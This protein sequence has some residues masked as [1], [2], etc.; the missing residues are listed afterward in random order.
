[1][2]T[3]Y[4]T[5]AVGRVGVL[6]FAPGQPNDVQVF[7]GGQLVV[8]AARGDASF[9]VPN[10]IRPQPGTVDVVIHG[11]PGRFGTTQECTIEVPA[12]VVAQLLDNAGIPRRTPLRCITCHG[13][14]NPLIGPAAAQLLATAR[15][16]PVSAPDGFCVVA[17]NQ[18]RIDLGDWNPDPVFGGQQFDVRPPG[19]GQPGG[20]GQGRFVP[21]VP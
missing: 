7:H 21:F 8:I 12:D 15:N 9:N 3:P 18:I 10:L 4:N 6:D 20:Q 14:E 2:G 11:A 16:S 17:P 13:G 19:G 5:P 1:M